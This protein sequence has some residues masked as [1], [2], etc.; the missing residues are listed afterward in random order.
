MTIDIAFWIMLHTVKKKNLFTSESLF[1]YA[2]ASIGFL[3]HGA[4]HGLI[5]TRLMCMAVYTDPDGERKYLPQYFKF[6]AANPLSVRTK[7]MFN[8]WEEVFILVLAVPLYCLKRIFWYLFVGQV[9]TVQVLF[10]ASLCCF[11]ISFGILFHTYP[12]ASLSHAGF[13]YLP[14]GHHF[15][16]SLHRE[17]H[18]STPFYGWSAFWTSFTMDGNSYSSWTWQRG[19]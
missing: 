3:K 10:F 14:L 2:Y 11:W 19:S 4:F 1:Q 8:S 17:S 16:W 9:R 15:S 5:C 18:K 6:I 12:Y 7:V 13:I